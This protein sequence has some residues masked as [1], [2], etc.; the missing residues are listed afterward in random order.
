MWAG[1]RGGDATALMQQQFL[2][3]GR[4][5]SQGESSSGSAHLGLDPGVLQ[6][7]QQ[8]AA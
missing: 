4:H 6:R 5:V 1:P 8:G 2:E 7:L 3:P